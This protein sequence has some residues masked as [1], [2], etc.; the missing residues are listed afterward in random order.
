MNSA[1]SE[2]ASPEEAVTLEEVP[3]EEFR[4]EEDAAEKPPGYDTLDFDENT[5]AA[6]AK[7]LEQ[8]YPGSFTVEA[9]P[10]YKQLFGEQAGK[11]RE[12]GMQVCDRPRRPRV[13]PHTRSRRSRTEPSASNTTIGKVLDWIRRKLPR[14]AN[15]LVV[16]LIVATILVV[17]LALPFSM[18]V[19]GKSVCSHTHTIL[20]PR[21]GNEATILVVLHYLVTEP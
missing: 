19:V 18:V 21:H 20:I 17:A 11:N 7:E 2:T 9:P 6:K 14:G 16:G 13:R 5:L 15:R 3:V 4:E 12:S 1:G 8:A 10:D